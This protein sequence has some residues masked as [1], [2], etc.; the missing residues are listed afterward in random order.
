MSH[1]LLNRWRDVPGSQLVTSGTLFSDLRFSCLPSHV[2]LW[3]EH[4]ITAED[5]ADLPVDLVHSPILHWIE[6][7]EIFHACHIIEAIVLEN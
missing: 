3:L 7:A 4:V 5:L 6:H 1:R 2:E